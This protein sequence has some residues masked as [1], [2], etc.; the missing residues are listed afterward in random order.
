MVLRLGLGCHTAISIRQPVTRRQYRNDGDWT[1]FMRI[2]IAAQTDTGRRKQNN[3]DCYGVFREDVPNLHLFDEGALLCVADGLGGHVG[4]EI[5][6]KLAVSILK[7][8]LKEPAPTP[9]EDPEDDRGY[10]PV[11]E[12]WI[13][14]A[15]TSIHQTNKDLVR[16][17][18]PMGT[19]LLAALVTPRKV[20]IG[21]VGDSRCYHIRDGEILEK[22]EDH[23]W[24]DE[25]V[26]LGLMSRAEAEG[27]SRRNLVT[28]S[29]GTHPEVTVDTYLWHV[30]PGDILLL[31][32]DGLI[33]MVK[34]ADIRAEFQKKG[35]PAEIAQRLVQLANDNG[36]KDNI[37]VIVANI[38]PTL[39]HLIARKSRAFF[40]KHGAKAVW[41]SLALLLG[42]A[43]GFAAGYFYA[44]GAFGAKP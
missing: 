25:Q 15:N 38:S 14:R 39:F 41:A 20:F 29:I 32:T 5:A 8:M 13:L 2:D 17:G 28:R 35:S 12:Q 42:L 34:D 26:K 16:T 37:T 30:V 21:T 33:N 36:G 1:Y 31:C 18:R 40:A 44:L 4:G 3:E 9:P 19:T 27:D 23:S 11:L 10:L 7:D 24:V 22:T 43:A 6:S